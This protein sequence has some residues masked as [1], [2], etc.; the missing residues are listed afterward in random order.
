M[1][2]IARN[3]RTDAEKLEALGVLLQQVR[4]DPESAS[5]LTPSVV[6]IPPPAPPQLNT[7]A[8]PQLNLNLASSQT[9]QTINGA[10]QTLQSATQAILS[11][12]PHNH[13]VNNLRSSSN[14]L[15]L[16]SSGAQ[17]APRTDECWSHQGYGVVSCSR[18]RHH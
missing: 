11:S 13:A 4:G 9:T 6:L 10:T 15:V 12:P 18:C 2:S 7:Q 17:V 5:V 14:E 1:L 16:V 3:M 8:Q